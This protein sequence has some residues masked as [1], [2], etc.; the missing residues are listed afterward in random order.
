MKLNRNNYFSLEANKKYLSVSQYKSFRPEYGGCE[1]Q[2]VAILNG[3]YIREEKDCFLQGKY[4]HSWNEGRL[5]KFREEHPELYKKKDGELLKKYEDMNT[6][7][8]RIKRDKMFMLSLSGEKEKIFTAEL[9]GVEW[10]I[11]ID[12][13]FSDRERMT[14]LKVVKKLNT[15]EYNSYTKS[16]ESIIDQYGYT[17][18]A[19]LYLE[20]EKRAN[21]RNNYFDFFLSIV[22]KE[23][24]PDI[25][26]VSF[27]SD[28][29]PVDVFVYNQL[30]V[31]EYNI[32]RII[33]LKKG[34]LE[35]VRCNYCD[36]CKKTKVLT[37]STHY[38]DYNIH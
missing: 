16:R 18:G 38:T 35:P 1:A 36:Y 30:S 23:K 13:Y 17:L 22:T 34:N 20:I 2:A 33:E 4:V 26:I 10:K 15:A 28:I 24:E 5:D 11:M 8:D 9:F 7:I 29:E 25:D 27:G 19:A 37:K 12:S 14:D 31:L 21:K 3:E 6:V 32:P